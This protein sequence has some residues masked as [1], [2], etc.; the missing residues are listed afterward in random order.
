MWPSLLK[1]Q[2]TELKLSC[3]NDPV[4]KNY[5]YSNCDL[6]CSGVIGLDMTENRI[7][8]CPSRDRQYY[9][10]DYGGRAGIHTGFRTITLVPYIRSLPHL[11]KL[12]LSYDIGFVYRRTDRHGETSIL[13]YNFVAG[14]INMSKTGCNSLDV[15]VSYSYAT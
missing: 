4:V 8:I 11:T 9:V 1:I 13:P 7:C 5:I 6:D 2:Y 14:G 12:K 15:T 10:I 3:G